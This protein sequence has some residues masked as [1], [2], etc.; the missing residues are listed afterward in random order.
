[1]NWEV[2]NRSVSKNSSNQNL[3]IRKRAKQAFDELNFRSQG[4]EFKLNFPGGQKM[5]IKS[6]IGIDNYKY[7]KKEH[8]V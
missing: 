3:E 7:D 5:V 4:K 8:I 2:F 6:R 1:M